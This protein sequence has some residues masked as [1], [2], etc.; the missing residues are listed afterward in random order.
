MT[1][2]GASE[3]RWTAKRPRSWRLMTPQTGFIQLRAWKNDETYPRRSRPPPAG[4][5]RGGA[6]AAGGAQAAAQA[7][8]A[9]STAR[10]SADGQPG[11]IVAIIPSVSGLGP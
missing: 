4:A 3:K 7:R 5:P 1:D 8:R 2:A 9:S 6:A 11:T 10:L